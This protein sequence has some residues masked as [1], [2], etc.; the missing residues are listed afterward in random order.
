MSYVRAVS[1]AAAL[2]NPAPMVRDEVCSSEE[3][4]LYLNHVVQ[5]VPK[6]V[7][8]EITS[9]LLTAG[10]LICFHLNMSKYSSEWV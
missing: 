4:P 10:R 2:S 1:C 6:Y 5:I 7:L 9:S 3:T 8:T